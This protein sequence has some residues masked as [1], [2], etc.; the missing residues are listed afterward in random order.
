MSRDRLSWSEGALC[1]RRAEDRLPENGTTA[2]LKPPLT[3]LL[4]LSL[5]QSATAQEKTRDRDREFAPSRVEVYKT[6]GDVELK[7]NIFNPPGHRATDKRPAIVFFFGGGW[8]GGSPGQFTQQS[9]YLASRGM[10]AMTAEYR[11]YSRNQAQVVDCIADA[12]SAVR[13]ARAHAEKL[14]IDPD[15]IASAGGSAGGHLAAAVGTL[16]GFDEPNEDAKISSRPNAM[17][18]FNPA[19]DLRAAAFSEEFQQ[20]RH[21]EIRARMGAEP[22]KISP[23]LHVDKSTPPA[24]IFHG[25]AD[26]TVPFHQ[27]EAFAE[28][29]K[30]AGVRCQVV[31][32]EG[33][34]HGF[35]NFGRGGNAN[36]A[37]TT[38]KAD[39]FLTSLGYLE[40]KPNIEQFLESLPQSK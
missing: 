9:R 16:D 8:R 15:R 7:M 12:K 37:A 39:D 22:E 29:M 4:V 30:Q 28:A 34:P 24:I 27:A 2:M 31:G 19:L 23:T 13:W 10:V 26:T 5:A 17:L 11:V 25:E 3:L 1:R 35:F 36:F 40:G 32:F 6:V 21:P 18:L 14:G 20:N 33:Q 38:R